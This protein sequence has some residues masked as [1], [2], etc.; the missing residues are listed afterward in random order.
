MN[1]PKSDKSG[2]VT[3]EREGNFMQTR[4]VPIQLVVAAILL[5]FTCLAYGQERYASVYLKNGDRLTGRWLASDDRTIQIVFQEKKLAI[6]LDQ[7]ATI[8]FATDLSL[9]PDAQAEK[10]FRNGKSL[11]EL[12]L[13][14]KAKNQF[15]AAI[16]EFPKYADA[17]Y[18]L[19][20]LLREDGAIDEA[21][22][23]FGRV[24]K[25]TPHSYNL[26]ADF[27]T[28]A[29][30]YLA[31]EAFRKAADTYLLIFN[32]YPTHPEAA[33]AGYSAGFILTER[34]DATAEALKILQEAVRRF[35]E[36]D[37]LAKA[38]YL[39]GSLQSEVGQPQVAVE[40][41]TIFIQEHPDSKW[42]DDA[43]VARGSAYKQLRMNNEALADFSTANA[44][45]TDPELRAIIQ[46][47]REESA[48]TIYTVSDNLPSN[49]IQA[50][51]VNGD[52][53]WVGTP[54]GLAR[55]NVGLGT[56]EFRRESGIE[57][58]NSLNLNVPTNVRALAVYA[59]AVDVPSP[60][61]VDESSPSLIEEA[62]EETEVWIGTLNQGV[63]RYNP[64]TRSYVNYNTLNGLAHNQISD[65]E[66]GSNDVWVATFSG[67]ARYSRPNDEWTVYDRTTSELPAD[68][69]VA[70]A[71]TPQTVW[72]GISDAGIAIFDLVYD[73]WRS[74]NLS[75]MVPEVVGNSIASFDV[76]GQSVYFT[77]YS[78]KHKWNGYGKSDWNGLIGE[79]MTVTQTDIVPIEDTYIAVGQAD[80]MMPSPPLWIATNDAVYYKS[81][82]GWDSIG[83]PAD[84]I[85]DRVTVNCIELS[86]GT[87]WIGTSNGLAKI[88]TNAVGIQ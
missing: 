36:S 82:S 80:A 24:A 28:A 59:P 73:S 40:T 74:A 20:L 11:L 25:I 67:V 9:I 23:Y 8:R 85:G 49:N 71:V 58:L 78:Q 87:A 46:R 5:L 61:Q 47:K 43:Y 57:L 64:L 69:I 14:G 55:I 16:E 62:V 21:L 4:L 1:R 66:F 32:Y 19:G 37:D 68:N 35:P 26:A 12:G 53:L 56:W 3:G 60:T 7:I 77:C 30:S 51:A 18:N 83:Y 34:L 39:I 79:G 81:T 22:D 17:H 45:T 31:A 10:H 72:A 50:I 6:G 27:K 76:G 70:L 88:D 52:D 29:D 15:E 44:I 84:Q 75:D 41:L 54:K 63:I 2:P 13:R 42:I 86:N 38:E 65:I 48:W 33:H